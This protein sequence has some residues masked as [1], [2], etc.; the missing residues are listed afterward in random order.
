MLTLCQVPYSRSIDRLQV[1][2]ITRRP[3]ALFA[4]TQNQALL[5]DQ[6]DQATP[7]PHSRRKTP[8]EVL[9]QEERGEICG[10]EHGCR[11]GESPDRF[12]T[13]RLALGVRRFI[14]LYEIQQETQELRLKEGET[15]VD[16]LHTTSDEVRAAVCLDERDGEGSTAL[17]AGG[18]F[19]ALIDP[20][21]FETTV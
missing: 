21:G 18:D 13:M 10:D 12:L 8:V 9:M 4:I 1:R 11:D 15:V 3:P 7:N 19:I 2:D 17:L 14:R 5:V 20:C 6:R 16:C